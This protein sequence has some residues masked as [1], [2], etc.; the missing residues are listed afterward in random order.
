MENEEIRLPDFFVPQ[1]WVLEYSPRQKAFHVESLEEA[2]K[3]NINNM[4]ADNLTD[5]GVI[6]MFKTK[7]EA[8]EAGFY[9]TLNKF[10]GKPLGER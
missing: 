5:Y 2:I 8:H 7:E 10:N 4:F 1:A 3:T 6:G 9:F